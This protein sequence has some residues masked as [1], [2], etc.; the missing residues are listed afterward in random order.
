MEPQKSTG[1]V[2][3]NFN[4]ILLAICVTLSG[5]ALKSIEDLKTQLA[6]E[7]PI[8]N[9]NSSAIMSINEVDKDQTEK[10]GEVMQRLSIIETMQSDRSKNKN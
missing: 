4:T 6:G 7:V 1:S 8:I 10:L 2:Q 9:A 3:R 5:W